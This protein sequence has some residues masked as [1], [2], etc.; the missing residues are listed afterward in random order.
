MPTWKIELMQPGCPFLDCSIT[1]PPILDSSPNSIESENSFS[2]IIVWC[3]NSALLMCVSKSS[4]RCSIELF[5]FPWVVVLQ[6]VF[7]ST[8]QI[9][10]FQR[11]NCTRHSLF[12]GLHIIFSS[13]VGCNNLTSVKNGCHFFLFIACL[14]KSSGV[15]LK[16]EDV[17]VSNIKIDLTRG[18]DNPLE[19]FL[20][21]ECYF[22]IDFG[23]TYRILTITFGWCS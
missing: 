23:T 21:F 2:W 18:K 15:L 1:V 16:E 10:A 3:S 6:S 12:T 9:G 5:C 20:I 13:W 22:L 19:R 8:G 7:C 4:V 17:A 14:Q 11:Y